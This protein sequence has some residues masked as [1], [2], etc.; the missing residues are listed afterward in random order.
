MTRDTTRDT[1][2]HDT[3]EA[4]YI[5]L[6]LEYCVGG[7][8]SDYLKKHK[9]LSEDT[10]RSFLRQLGAFLTGP[11]PRL[12]LDLSIALNC[13][14]WFFSPRSIGTQVSAQPEHCT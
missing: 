10:A 2:R 13:H 4:E 12:S 3:Q 9:R 6:I 11:R 7:D 14:H 5:Y 8:F 1:T